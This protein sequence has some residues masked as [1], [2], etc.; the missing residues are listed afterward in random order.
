MKKP[1][2]AIKNLTVPTKRK[3]NFINIKNFE[4][5]RGAC[6][7][8]NGEMCSGKTLLI[9]VISGNE[10]KYSG[11]V[12]YETK[13]LKEYKSRNLASQFSYVKQ[14]EKRSYFKTVKSY[15]YNEIK[16][17]TN[18]SDSINSKL[19]NIIKVM[20]LKLILDQ[21]LTVLTPGQF[22]WVDLASNIASFPKV[23]I[24]DEIELHLNMKYIKSLCKILY[25]KSN[26]EGVTIIA[27]TQNKEFFTSLSSINISI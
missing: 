24:I 19:N 18:S 10:N 14:I 2:I 6:Y 8:I 4:F 26:Y 22:R 7:L 1:I 21:K 16:S 27:T 23:L 9:N 15:I 11:D 12:F 13:L 20:D 3:Q 25:R 5:H 17:K